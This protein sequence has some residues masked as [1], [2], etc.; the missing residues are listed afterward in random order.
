MNRVYLAWAVAAVVRAKGPPTPSG[1]VDIHLPTFTDA[2]PNALAGVSNLCANLSSDLVRDVATKSEGAKRVFFPLLRA[3]APTA[4]TETGLVRSGIRL[5][6]SV[7]RATFVGDSVVRELSASFASLTGR[8]IEGSFFDWRFAAGNASGVEA[9]RKFLVQ[10]QDSR[11]ADIIFV[12]GLGLHHLLRSAPCAQRDDPLKEHHRVVREYLAMFREV[13]QVLQR[14]LVFVGV[15]PVDST[16]ILLRPAKADY[17]DFSDF[18]FA[19]LWDGVESEAFA[20]G[21]LPPAVFH[22]R[23]SALAHRCP[24][25]RCDGM[26]FASFDRGCYPSPALWD[27]DLAKFLLGAFGPKAKAPK[28][29]PSP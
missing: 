17:K 8:P 19:T 23:P 28:G 13:A 12:G 7:K 27:R 14:P 2:K 24:G 1:L 20:A 10:R 26:H 25:V 11:S 5:E 9:Y 22:F 18:S 4:L 15:M 21:H 6:T 3:S 16:T 29:F